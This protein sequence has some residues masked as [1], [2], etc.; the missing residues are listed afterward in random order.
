MIRKNSHKNSHKNFAPNSF[1][2]FR[3]RCSH[4][5]NFA[6]ISAQ[7]FAPF[8][9]LFAATRSAHFPLDEITPLPPHPPATSSYTSYTSY[10]PTLL[11][12]HVFRSCYS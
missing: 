3:T 10:T 1:A 5:I 9:N 2:P 8:R 4:Q 6:P 7:F 11:H 12:L